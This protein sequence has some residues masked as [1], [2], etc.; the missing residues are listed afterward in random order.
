MSLNDPYMC[1]RLRA[2]VSVVLFPEEH[3]VM[4]DSGLVGLIVIW[5]TK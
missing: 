3:L 1:A 4:L 5:V 2:C